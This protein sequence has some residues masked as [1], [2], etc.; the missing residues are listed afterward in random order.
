MIKEIVKICGLTKSE[1]LKKLSR[2]EDSG[3]SFEV[4]EDCLDAKITMSTPR[5]NRK[6]EDVKCAVYNTT[7]RSRAESTACLKTSAATPTPWGFP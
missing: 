4:D 3:V 2:F 5:S 6:F 1:I 7:S